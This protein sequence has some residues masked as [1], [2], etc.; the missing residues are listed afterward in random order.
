M[1]A[2]SIVWHGYR[3]ARHEVWVMGS[4]SSVIIASL[5]LRLRSEACRGFVA[6]HWEFIACGP[7]GASR[8]LSLTPPAS[9]QQWRQ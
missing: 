9:P 6:M 5:E 7:Y 2:V 4:C 3:D 1:L 8:Q